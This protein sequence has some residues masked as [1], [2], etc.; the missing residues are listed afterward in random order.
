MEW[1]Q[2]DTIATAW[3]GVFT[4]GQCDFILYMWNIVWRR[5]GTSGLCV[6]A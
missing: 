1:T 3:Q 5:E 4:D 6:K 2:Q